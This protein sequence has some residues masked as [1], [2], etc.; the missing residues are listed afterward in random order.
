MKRFYKNIMRNS[1][2]ENCMKN[3]KKVLI[4]G[5]CGFIGMHLSEKLRREGYQVLGVDKKNGFDLKDRKVVD[6]LPDV[7][8]VVHLAAYNGTK[9][10]YKKPFDVV[11]DNTLPTINL[12]NRYKNSVDR[13]VFAGTCESYAGSIEL[14]S[15]YLPTPETVPLSITDITNPRWSYGG[16]KI[17][18]EIS[19]IAAYEQF[20]MDFS[21][22]RY[23]NIYGSGQVDHFFPEF[24]HKVKNGNLE[25]VGHENTRSFLYIDDAIE[26]TQSVI[27]CPK[28]KNNIINIGSSEEVTIRGAAQIILDKMGVKEELI[29]K[30]APEGSVM[31]RVPCTKKLHDICGNLTNISL[32]QGIELILEVL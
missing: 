7:D 19:V 26:Y 13:F 3:Y 28:A 29:L 21:I 15:S 5:S 10:F 14:D 12:L 16:S 31:R 4:T 23:H 25:L 32:S 9:W 17:G 8:I 22:I 1:A 2:M 18:N 11:L 27:E 30:D 24:I 6:N 20:G